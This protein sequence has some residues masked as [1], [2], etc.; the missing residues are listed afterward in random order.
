MSILSSLAAP[1]SAVSVTAILGWVA[2]R[3]GTLKI[4]STTLAEDVAKEWPSILELAA[5]VPAIETQ[6]AGAATTDSV[7]AAGI[8]L[9]A[10]VEAAVH[11]EFARLFPQLVKEP[12]VATTPTTV[13]V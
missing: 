12:V 5:K 1:V 4:G 11:A 6:L 2:H 9:A 7:T 10:S 13:E 3:L 8:S